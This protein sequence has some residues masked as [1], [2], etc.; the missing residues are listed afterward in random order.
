MIILDVAF[1]AV[2]VETKGFLE[3]DQRKQIL[4][5]LHLKTHSRHLKHFFSSLTLNGRG[6]VEVPV[7]FFE[8]IH[9]E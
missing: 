8:I 9:E 7:R 2:P 1:V 3:A 5:E 6:Y 4:F